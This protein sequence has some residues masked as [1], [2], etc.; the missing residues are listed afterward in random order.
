[1]ALIAETFRC[2]SPISEAHAA[3]AVC[4]IARIMTVS[5]IAHI[6]SAHIRGRTQINMALIA[7]TF[8]CNSPII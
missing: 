1:M 4:R 5:W 7:E 6:M 3:V 8:R 2:N